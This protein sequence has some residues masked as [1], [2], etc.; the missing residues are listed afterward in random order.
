MK[1]RLKV[2]D[3]IKGF[4]IDKLIKLNRLNKGDSYEIKRKDSKS[5]DSKFN[6]RL[7]KTYENFYLFENDKGF[8]ECFLKIDLEIN[9]FVIERVRKEIA[10]HEQAKKKQNYNFNSSINNRFYL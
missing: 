8:R 2:G 5:C 10:L 1:Q 6:G 4:Y 9:Y 3:N 7:I